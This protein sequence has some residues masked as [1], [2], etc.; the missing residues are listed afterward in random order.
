[1]SERKPKSPFEWLFQSTAL[2]CGAAVLLW[3]TVQLLAQ[4]WIVLVALAL[5]VLAIFVVRAIIV[6]RQQRW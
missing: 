5:I 3:L 1:M 2:L 4:V 6:T